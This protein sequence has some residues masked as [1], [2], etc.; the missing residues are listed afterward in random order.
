[1]LY[2]SIKEFY[3]MSRSGHHTHL[4]MGSKVFQK[5]HLKLEWRRNPWKWNLI[6]STVFFW[7]PQKILTSSFHSSCKTLF[8]TSQSIFFATSKELAYLCEWKTCG[9]LPQRVEYIWPRTDVEAWDPRVRQSR[10]RDRCHQRS[11]WSSGLHPVNLFQMDK[12]ILYVILWGI[13]QF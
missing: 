7:C 13:S 3:D 10:W 6:L 8:V 9:C 1:M 5:I 12:T 2:F 4:V 11:Q